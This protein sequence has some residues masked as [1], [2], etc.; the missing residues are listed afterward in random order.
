MLGQLPVRSM[1]LTHAEHESSLAAR[2]LTRTG[3][4]ENLR[5]EAHRECAAARLEGVAVGQ[6]R[7][8]QGHMSLEEYKAARM[9][10]CWD[11]CWCTKLCTIYGDVL[12]PCT[13]WL[14]LHKD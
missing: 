5:R 3:S 1:A 4:E 6:Y 9:C 12:C 11:S 10:V 7:Y 14:A 8:Y 2:L 13:E